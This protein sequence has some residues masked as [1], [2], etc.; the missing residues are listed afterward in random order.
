MMAVAFLKEE[1]N[2]F[3]WSRYFIVLLIPI[4]T[5]DQQTANQTCTSVSGGACPTPSPTQVPTPAPTQ[6]PTP[7]PQVP[8]WTGSFEGSCGS[9]ATCGNI[10]SSSLTCKCAPD[11]DPS[12]DYTTTSTCYQSCCPSM[13]VSNDNGVLTCA[14]SSSSL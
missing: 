9:S 10:A 1:M 13:A 5:N 8:S 6:V 7:A 4:T 2:E 3:F 14:V 11:G 12:S